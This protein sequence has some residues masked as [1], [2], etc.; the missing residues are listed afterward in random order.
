MPVTYEQ[1]T[2]EPDAMP[3]REV[4]ARAG[5]TADDVAR[6]RKEALE[7]KTEKLLKVKGGI[8]PALLP[9]NVSIIS[10]GYEE[11]IL[12]HTTVDHRTRLEA[13]EAVAQEMGLKPEKSRCGYDGEQI[14]GRRPQGDRRKERRHTIIPSSGRKCS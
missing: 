13:A 8:S 6:V 2:K 4:Y 12:L 1:L 7:A 10:L 11:T 14:V 3:M 9:H 5:V